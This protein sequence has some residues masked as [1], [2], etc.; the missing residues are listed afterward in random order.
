MVEKRTSSLI[1]DFSLA[2]WELLAHALRSLAV[3]F[4]V[5]RSMESSHG[6]KYI[7]E[8]EIETPI[9]KPAAV[10]TIWIIDNGETIGRLVTAYPHEG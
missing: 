7:V 8:G 10:R 4:P 2:A 5:V 3:N 9:G 1:W 6:K